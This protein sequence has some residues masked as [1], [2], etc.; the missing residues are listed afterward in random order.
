MSLSRALPLLSAVL[1]VACQG[2]RPDTGLQLRAGEGCSAFT[3]E[4]SGV[5]PTGAEG[6]VLTA[7]DY[8]SHDVS[9]PEGCNWQDL[10]V[11]LT[12]DLE[13]ED[14]DLSIQDAEGNELSASG[15]FN[16][17]SGAAEERAS[18]GAPSG[19][20]RIVVVSYANVETPYTLSVSVNP[21]AGPL[22]LTDAGNIGQTPVPRT[23]VAVIDSGINM[24][25]AHWYAGSE[26]YPDAAP[27]AVTQ[28]VLDEFGVTPSCIME[29]TRSGDFAAD[30]ELDVA[31]GEWSKAQLCDVVWFKG[32]NVLASSI[33]AG[34][35]PVMPDDEGDTHGTGTSASV[36]N[37]N[38]ETVLWFLEGV[39]DASEVK[40]F[41]HPA[42]D[43]VST[44]YGPIGSAPLPGNLT[45]SFK[46]VYEM[47]K[48][49]FGACDNTPALAQGDTTCGPWWSIGLA[50]FEESADNEPETSSS[51]RQSVSG[52]FPDFI[53]DFSQ[54][55][56]YCQACE[57]GYEDWVGGTSF[58]TPRSA[59]IASRILLQAR[60][61]AGHLGGIDTDGGSE[62]LMVNAGGIAIS[63]WQLRR[64]L[65]EAAWVPS[66]ADYDPVAAVFEF[67]PGYPI[68]P[69]APWAVIGWG[70]LSDLPEAGVVDAAL[71][72]LG[73]GGEPTFKSADFCS[74]NTANIQARKFYWD[75]VN[76]DS[77]TY[78]N[79]PDP[80][81]YL[82]C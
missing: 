45:D 80:D 55:L 7:A 12:W 35:I 4:F 38:P 20:Y 40:A 68:P 32:T 6:I 46:G 42:V 69:V 24:Y 65:E 57:D 75:N 73:L 15:D 5:A 50:G 56:P 41:G 9:V 39:A 67:G 59:G 53:A 25:H 47:G 13:V 8:A 36:L 19:D 79:A 30:Y 61:Q 82:G 23:V 26:I 14:L 31:R 22:Q 49:H 16:A 66:A 72:H 78:M 62:P 10:S 21:S 34:S 52:N 28:P 81:P 1:L 63:N 76:V 17:L 11:I 64:A 29:L 43:F 3:Q 2:G 33:S 70:V 18:V 27:K 44:S 77:E 60:R 71:A 58:A 54:T 74:F 48:L 37:A 51:G